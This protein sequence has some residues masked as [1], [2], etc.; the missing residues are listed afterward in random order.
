MFLLMSRNTRAIECTVHIAFQPYHGA[1]NLKYTTE[2]ETTISYSIEMPIFGGGPS[3]QCNASDG[4]IYD[5]NR[6]YTWPHDFERFFYFLF[7]YPRHGVP[8]TLIYLPKI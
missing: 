8:T 4:W 2:Q 3:V 5:R 7:I 6:L 1:I